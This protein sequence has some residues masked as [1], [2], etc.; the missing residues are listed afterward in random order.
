MMNHARINH[1][2]Q[3]ALASVLANDDDDGRHIIEKLRKKKRPQC[4]EI[5]F[6]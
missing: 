2:I 3:L 5:K 4:R 6:Y 1:F